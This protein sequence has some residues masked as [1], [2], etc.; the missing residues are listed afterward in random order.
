MERLVSSVKIK[1]ETYDL[2]TFIIAYSILKCQQ[3]F[4]YI[5]LDSKAF[6]NSVNEKQNTCSHNLNKAEKLT[7]LSKATY[8]V[9]DDCWLRICLYISCLR[10]QK[11]LLRMNFNGLRHFWTCVM[12][13]QARMHWYA[14]IYTSLNFVM[15][16]SIK[17]K[18]RKLSGVGEASL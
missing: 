9:H 1:S 17:K 8:W 11:D 14:T 2:I 4:R 3:Y 18:G 15:W 7:I 16:I 12:Y 13:I 6:N 10:V 5:T